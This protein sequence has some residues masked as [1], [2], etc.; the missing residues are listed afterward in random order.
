MS[1]NS[2]NP[3][4]EFATATRIIFGEGKLA[5]APETIKG[6]GQKVLVVTGSKPKRAAPLL[7]L[8]KEF[9]C[10]VHCLSLIHI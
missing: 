7:E 1:G 8:L 3:A 4:F 5:E 10:A 9:D 2:T 6:F